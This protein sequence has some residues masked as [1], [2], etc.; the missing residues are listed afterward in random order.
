V[1]H[2]DC[3]TTRETLPHAERIHRRRGSGS[4]VV[5][6]LQDDAD[7]ART[8]AERLSLTLPVLLEGE[9]FPLARALGVEVVP[10]LFLVSPGGGIEQRSE[11]FR[12]SDLEAFAG[13]LG[14]AGSLFSGDEKVPTFRPG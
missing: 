6:V 5:A 9:P 10:T 13:R 11:G 3:K 4:S 12:R 7:T 14:V 2:R 1:G 8:L